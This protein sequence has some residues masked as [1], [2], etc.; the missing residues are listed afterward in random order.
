MRAPPRPRFQRPR[1]QLVHLLRIV[2]PHARVIRFLQTSATLKP[3]HHLQHCNHPSATGIDIIFCF[4]YP[5]CFGFGW[6]SFFFV[7]SV[8]HMIGLHRDEN[9][10]FFIFNRL[11][12]LYQCFYYTRISTSESIFSINIICSIRIVQLL[13][14]EMTILLRIFILNISLL[15]GVFR[16]LVRVGQMLG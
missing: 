6:G 13:L 8:G 15:L 10:S 4:F 1:T 5:Q 9:R 2:Q 14:L 11:S 3:L 12:F 16:F 7:F